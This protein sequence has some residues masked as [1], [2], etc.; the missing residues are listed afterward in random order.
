[1]KIVK[2]SLLT[3]SVALTTT[4]FANTPTVGTAMPSQSMPNTTILHHQILPPHSTVMPASIASMPSQTTNTPMVVHPN[5]YTIIVQLPGNATTG[6]Q[7]Y[8]TRYNHRLLQLDGYHY[9]TQNTHLM[10]APGTTAF[11]FG[12]TPAF[13]TAPQMTHIKFSYQRGWESGAAKTKTI[14]VMSAPNTASPNTMSTTPMPA[15]VMTPPADQSNVYPVHTSPYGDPGAT[16]HP[17]TVN[18]QEGW[19]THSSDSSAPTGK[20]VKN[21]M[22]L[23][24]S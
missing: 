21:W 24:S 15:K 1:M 16:S 19:T 5:Q 13:H 20:H 6:Y 14:T 18:T 17:N 12:V 23:P 9:S 11:V 8:L 4:A 3:I 22:T 2:L 10:G 7:W